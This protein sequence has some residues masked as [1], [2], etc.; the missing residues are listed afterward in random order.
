M[1]QPR[2]IVGV[3]ANSDAAATAETFVAY[4]LERT[5][6][7]QGQDSGLPVCVAAFEGRTRLANGGYTV[8]AGTAPGS[9]NAVEYGRGPFTAEEIQS[10]ID[11]MQ[12]VDIACTDDKVVTDAVVA[13]LQTY[14]RDEATLEQAVET[15]VQKINLYRAQ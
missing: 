15:V 9:T 2:A 4:L 8:S 13:G 3:S 6:Q 14:C 1:F 11:L 5:Q 12:S 10:C 7:M